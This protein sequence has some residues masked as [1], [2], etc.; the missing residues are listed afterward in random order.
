MTHACLSIICHPPSATHRAYTHHPRPTTHNSQLTTTH[1]PLSTQCRCC[2]MKESWVPLDSSSLTTPTLTRMLREGGTVGPNGMKSAKV[3]SFSAKPIGAGEGFFSDMLLLDI[4]YE[5]RTVSTDDSAT[6]RSL[7]NSMEKAGEP[8]VDAKVEY[9][10]RARLKLKF[11]ARCQRCQ[12]RHTATPHHHTTSP[13]LVLTGTSS[14]NSS[15][16]D[17]PL[18]VEEHRLPRKLVAKV[19]CTR[20]SKQRSSLSCHP[21]LST[22]SYH[23]AINPSHYLATPQSPC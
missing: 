1:P 19:C 16:L 21:T 11:R 9:G 17:D 15:I 13:H 10:F 14:F 4:E 5:D 22:P 18:L 23:Q 12:H 6:G 8:R 7:L 2:C 3:M 20:P